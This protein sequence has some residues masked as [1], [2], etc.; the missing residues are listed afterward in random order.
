MR[1][2]KGFNWLEMLPMRKRGRTHKAQARGGVPDED[3]S[4]L[5]RG[6]AER[7]G[8]VCKSP[9]PLV[10]LRGPGGGARAGLGPASAQL[11][12]DRSPDWAPP[13]ARPIPEDFYLVT[14]TAGSPFLE[15][16]ASAVMRFLAVA[17][18]FLALS[19][20]ALAE[21]VKFKDCGEP[22]G[23]SEVPAPSAGA[24]DRI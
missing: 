6:G 8:G 24:P 2:E 12:S 5:P 10:W 22:R 15:L 3:G 11:A 20:S 21:P 19:A 18:L 4:R 7:M 14:E 1:K 9:E 23:Q 17:F 16:G 13:P